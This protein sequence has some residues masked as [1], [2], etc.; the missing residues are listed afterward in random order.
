M[1]N[2]FFLHDLSKKSQIFE[3]EKDKFSNAIWAY[4]YDLKSLLKYWILTKDLVT[5]IVFEN[6]DYYDFH[7]ENSED[8]DVDQIDEIDW[9][10]AIV[11]DG[12]EL[13]SDF[14]NIPKI[15]RNLVLTNILTLIE[16]LLR[17]VCFELDENFSLNGKGSYI[18]QYSYY[19]KNNCSILIAKNYLK[20]FEA[21]SHLRNS[22]VH[23][24]D[25]KIIPPES[26]KHIEQLCGPFSSL[27]WGT[28]N[29]H[30][31]ILFKVASDFGESFQNEYWKHF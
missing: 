29:I 2:E 30:I 14:T 3:L 18:Q 21:F 15:Q 16:K 28:E 26:R 25:P 10:E 13:E 17:D 22:F 27:D 23:K 7:P 24:F 8:L 20:S 5:E 12:D 6:S 4:Y 1:V 31:E 9:S 11:S 19:I